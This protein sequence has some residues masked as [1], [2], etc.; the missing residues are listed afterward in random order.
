[1]LCIPVQP[2]KT[3]SYI[4][5]GG[6]PWFDI[7][8]RIHSCHESIHLCSP[9]M[10]RARTGSIQPEVEV[11]DWIYQHPLNLIN[12]RVIFFALPS[13]P[14]GQLTVTFLEQRQSAGVSSG[15]RVPGKGATAV[16]HVHRT[17]FREMARKGYKKSDFQGDQPS[18]T[19]LIELFCRG[20]KRHQYRRITIRRRPSEPVDNRALPGA[21]LCA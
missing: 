21:C 12:N 9:S 13:G 17:K 19:F 6:L 18:D 1:M 16:R 7:E 8:C 11:K 10:S 5:V 3:A 15:R 20:M 2:E 14:A 4:S